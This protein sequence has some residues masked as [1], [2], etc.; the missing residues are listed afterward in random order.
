MKIG[1]FGN[2]NSGKSSAVKKLSIIL[3]N[4]TVVQIDVMRQQ[5]GDGSIK[6]E[7]MAQEKFISAIQNSDNVIFEFTGYG[8]IADKLHKTLS[9][10]SIV[11]VNVKTKVETCLARTAHKD[12]TLIPYP[13]KD[14]DINK[15]IKNLSMIFD[16]HNFIYEF[17]K[18]KS[19]MIINYR[20]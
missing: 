18:S 2:I 20:G 9:D 6:G 1:V 5:Y 4:H 13:Y 8:V 16:E 15:T 19:F 17:W 10:K 7:E 12:F 3:P 11:I 14:S